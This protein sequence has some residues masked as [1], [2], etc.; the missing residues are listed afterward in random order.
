[1]TEQGF[2][3]ELCQRLYSTEKSFLEHL[4][5]HSV[6]E[7]EALRKLAELGVSDPEKYE[8]LVWETLRLEYWERRK[9]KER[10]VE[11]SD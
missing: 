11:R 2:I 4:D 10:G 7:V 8:K 9:A 6:E 3:C 1:M 5:E